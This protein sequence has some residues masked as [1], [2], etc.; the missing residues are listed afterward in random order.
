MI[1]SYL[2]LSDGPLGHDVTSMAGRQEAIGYCHRVK[3][4]TKPVAA[5]PR[6]TLMIRALG[7]ALGPARRKLP[8]SVEAMGALK[9]ALELMRIDKQILWAPV[10]IGR[11]FALKLSELIDSKN[12]LAPEGRSP[13]LV[14]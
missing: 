1:L 13:I 14:S 4:G 6:V 12:R 2:A 5:M 10:L 7:R 9:G 11:V 3:T 8:I